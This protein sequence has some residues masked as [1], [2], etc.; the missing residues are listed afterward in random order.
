MISFQE[1][2]GL[3]FYHTFK[4]ASWSVLCVLAENMRLQD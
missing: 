4:L 2:T 3:R 1:L